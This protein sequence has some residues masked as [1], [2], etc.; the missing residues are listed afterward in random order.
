MT[1]DEGL[2]IKKKEKKKPV[3]KDRSLYTVNFHE[4][5]SLKPLFVNLQFGGENESIPLFLFLFL[6]LSEAGF[7]L[8]LSRFPSL[9]ESKVF[10][11][12]CKVKRGGVGGLIEIHKY[13]KQQQ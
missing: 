5:Y 11:C 9:I 3:I 7:E 8:E 12:I 13:K 2:S 1:E 10:C 4:S 6:L